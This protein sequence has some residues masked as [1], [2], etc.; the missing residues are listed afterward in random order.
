MRIQ[1]VG[2]IISAMTFYWLGQQ[3]I[4]PP[5]VIGQPIQGFVTNPNSQ[6]SAKVAVLNQVLADQSHN[7]VRVDQELSK[8][9]QKE[10]LDFRQKYRSLRPEALK[11]RGLI[12]YLLGRNIETQGDLEF[13]KEVLNERGCLSLNNCAITD[14][15]TLSQPEIASHLAFPKL[16]AIAAL[17]GKLAGQNSK[18]MREAI[19]VILQ[20]ARNSMNPLVVKAAI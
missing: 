13:L 8:L 9:N 5:M 2:L 19:E 1:L 17:K 15:E 16:M 10:R 18:K 12:V 20:G 7:D 6:V 3:L 14:Q 11:D 4:K